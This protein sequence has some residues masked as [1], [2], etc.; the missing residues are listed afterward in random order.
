MQEQ[1]IEKRIQEIKRN[2][3][4]EIKRLREKARDI[5]NWCYDNLNS[6]IR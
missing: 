4:E 2:S 1:E 5:K 3:E 6:K